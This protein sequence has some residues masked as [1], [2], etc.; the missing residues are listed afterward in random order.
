MGQVSSNS[1]ITASK[2]NLVDEVRALLSFGIDVERMNEQ[3]N[4]ALH[5]A[6]FAGHHLV[7]PPPPPHTHHLLP[8]EHTT[9]PHFTTGFPCI[10]TARA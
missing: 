3:R 2:S 5:V 1:L 6:C 10:S 8:P 9:I 4:N 7:S